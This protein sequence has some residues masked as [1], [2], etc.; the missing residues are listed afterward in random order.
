MKNVCNEVE[1]VH[2]S[3]KIVW[4]A[5]SVCLKED[6]VTLRVRISLRRDLYTG[7]KRT[8]RFGEKRERKGTVVTLPNIGA[9]TLAHYSSIVHN[10]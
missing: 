3:N 4:F 7:S 1:I 6:L 5:S 9:R 10:N 2:I 8:I